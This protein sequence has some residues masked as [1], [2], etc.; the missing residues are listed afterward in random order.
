MNLFEWA[1]GKSL[2]PQ[3]RLK[4]NQRALERTQRE[5]ERERRKL[6][7]QEKKLVSEIKKSAKNGQISAAKIQA[8]DL[9]RTKKYVEKFN[10]MKT[11]LQAISLRIQAVRSSDQM[12]QSMREAT[13]LLASMN[14]SMNLPQLQRI[15]MEFE[16]QSDL[17]DQRQEFMDEAID[18][19]MGNELDEDEEADEIV[20]RVLDEI[21]V[22]LNAKLQSTP[23]ELVTEPNLSETNQ[24]VAEPLGAWN[25]SSNPDDELQ[26]RL[27]SLK[28]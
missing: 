24:K 2:T 15:S 10:N 7:L 14:R 4:K 5:L 22:D 11:Q 23:Q 21:G 8:K 25:G 20:N 27:N 26:A 12:T 18:D 16:K 13:G 28:R 6:E 19:A 3:E 1:F 17:M 9:V